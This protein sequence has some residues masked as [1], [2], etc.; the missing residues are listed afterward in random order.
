MNRGGEDSSN[1]LCLSI[2]FPSLA[3][4]ISVMSW[5][6]S[7]LVSTLLFEILWAPVNA[8]RSCCGASSRGSPRPCL[9]KPPS[10]SVC[11]LSPCRWGSPVISLL[12]PCVTKPAWRTLS[13]RVSIGHKGSSS[14]TSHRPHCVQDVCWAVQHPRGTLKCYIMG[15]VEKILGLFF[16][17]GGQAMENVGS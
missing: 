16:S 15:M 11:V 8:T 17:G 4:L 2:S 9:E 1:N 5:L 6:S 3:L 10:Q 14:W 13:L 12:G 7:D